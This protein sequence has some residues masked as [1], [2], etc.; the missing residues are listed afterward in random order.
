MFT[1]LHKL[2]ENCFTDFFV[3]FLELEIYILK[4]S[5]WLVKFGHY[6]ER[7]ARHHRRV[8]NVLHGETLD[9]FVLDFLGN[10]V[11]ESALSPFKAV[12]V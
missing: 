2:V 1:V 7:L 3:K 10:L 11:A 12:I 6:E 5:V 8:L 4:T 9:F